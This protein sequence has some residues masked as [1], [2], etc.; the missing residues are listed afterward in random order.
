MWSLPP[1]PEQRTLCL[2]LDQRVLGEPHRLT[3]STPMATASE[4]MRRRPVWRAAVLAVAKEMRAFA[5]KPPPESC[6]RG[7]DDHA[8]RSHVWAIR[9]TVLALEF[10]IGTK[11]CR[12]E[13]ASVG[14]GIYQ[15]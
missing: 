8:A 7:Q 13:G 5:R 14:E 9:T 1:L 4:A 10:S 12:S 15:C 2:S 6:V 11:T 3:G